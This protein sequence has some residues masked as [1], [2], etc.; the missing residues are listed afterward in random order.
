MTRPYHEVSI[1]IEGVAEV[2]DPDGTVHRAEPGDVL[3][4]PP[5]KRGHLA[6]RDRRE[7]VLGD[8]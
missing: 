7:E 5:R 6:L 2:V 3:V 1:V 4:T 8:L